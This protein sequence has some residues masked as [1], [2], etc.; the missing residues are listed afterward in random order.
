MPDKAILF[1]FFFEKND[2]YS[3]AE[4]LSLKYVYTKTTT[5]KNKITTFDRLIRI[6]NLKANFTSVSLTTKNLIHLT[7]PS[8]LVNNTSTMKCLKL[9]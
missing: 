9:K 7:V 4:I 8:C 1:S 5:W 6:R 2:L 3:N